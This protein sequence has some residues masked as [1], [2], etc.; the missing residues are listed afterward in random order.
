MSVAFMPF[1]RS[2][3]ISFTARGMRPNTRV[4]PFFDNLDISIYVTPDGDH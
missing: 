4:F 1:I 3:T 2:R